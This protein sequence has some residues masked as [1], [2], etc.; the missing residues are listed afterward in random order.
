MNITPLKLLK[1]GFPMIPS[2]AGPTKKAPCIAW[3]E[4]QNRLPTK[5]QVLQMVGDILPGYQSQ[6]S[7]DNKDI[8]NQ[9]V[10]K[11]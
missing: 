8:T 9:M 1:L 10:C 2:G 6:E 5:E 11:R 3:A 4:F 7:G